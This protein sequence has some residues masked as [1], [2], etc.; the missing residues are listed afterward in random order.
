VAKIDPT[1]RVAEGAKLGAEVFIGPYCIIGPQVTLGDGCRLLAHV[2]IQGITEIGAG[3]KIQP[4]AS[5]GSPPQSVH[6]KGEASKLIIGKNCDIREG[7]TMN[8]GTAGGRMETRVGDNGMFMTGAHVG[9]DCIVGND[10]IFANNATLGGHVEIGNMAFMGGFGAVH[11]NV[12]VGEQAM[13]AGMVA[14]RRDV[15]PFGITDWTGHL[16]GLNLIGLKRRG[17][18]RETIHKL[19]AVYRALFLSDEG[20]LAERVEE[21]AKQYAEEEAVQKVIA[22]IRSAGKRRISTP[23]ARH[24]ED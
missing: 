23:S 20:T 17:F 9:H 14:V 3:A 13:I 8:T 12:R 19:R 2:S 10:V 16:S 4:F 15:I 5:L 21:V 24:E 11:Q 22:F 1:A 18:S 7:V 6:Y